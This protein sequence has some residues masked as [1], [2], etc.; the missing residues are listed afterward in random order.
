MASVAS[1]N[2]WP[3]SRRLRWL[4]GEFGLPVDRGSCGGCVVG[5][6]AMVGGWPAT[7]VG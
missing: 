6:P 1:S 7:M 5:S 4:L 3:A 2:G